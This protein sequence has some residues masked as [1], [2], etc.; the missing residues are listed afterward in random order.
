MQSSCGVAP[1]ANGRFSDN[2]M[3]FNLDTLMVHFL[4]FLLPGVAH[5]VPNLIEQ[6]RATLRV[7][8]NY[9]GPMQSL[10]HCRSLLHC[11]AVQF[12]YS[13]EQISVV[14]C[15]SGAVLQSTKVQSC[16]RRCSELS[17]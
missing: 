15:L 5:G 6:L 11:V 3:L 9:G 13:S 10:F 16:R 7:G 4:L 17:L 12:P 2:R 1:F 8:N 14:R